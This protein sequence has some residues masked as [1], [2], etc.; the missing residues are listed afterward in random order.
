[1]SLCAIHNLLQPC[2]ECAAKPPTPRPSLAALEALRELVTLKAMKDGFGVEPF[3]EHNSNAAIADYKRRRPLAWAAAKAAL[4]T[5]APQGSS[6]TNAE[7]DQASHNTTTPPSIEPP[8]GLR[9]AIYS[10]L[11]GTTM[12]RN[13]VTDRIIADLSPW[14]SARGEKT[15]G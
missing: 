10:H 12:E 5:P 13:I 3:G 14:L 6:S 7:H 11:R 9:S 15:D 4:S 1:M 8:E 2:F